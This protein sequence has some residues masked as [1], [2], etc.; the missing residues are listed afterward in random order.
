[1]RAIQTGCGTHYMDKVGAG[2][3]Q[4][5]TVGRT[6][7]I[8][9]ERYDTCKRAFFHFKIGRCNFKQDGQL[10]RAVSTAD[11]ATSD[12]STRTDFC[13]ES[14]F[15]LTRPPKNRASSPPVPGT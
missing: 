12:G 10:G 3:Q 1:M 7:I 5:K 13:Q 2:I 6:M 11:Y 9:G 8:C 15:S 4:F 14:V